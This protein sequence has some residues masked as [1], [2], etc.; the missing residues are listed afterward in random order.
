MIKIKAAISLLWEWAIVGWVCAAMFNDRWD[1]GA[2]GLGL[3]G[4]WILYGERSARLA[5]EEMV[6]KKVELMR[7]QHQ[8]LRFVDEGSEGRATDLD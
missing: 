2:F 6:R 8:L 5:R 7:M 4:V 3:L 1:V